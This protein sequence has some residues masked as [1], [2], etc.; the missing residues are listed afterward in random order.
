MV[1]EAE[2]SEGHTGSGIQAAQS[3]RLTAT[4]KTDSQRIRP[5]LIVNVVF[6]VPGLSGAE[7]AA[8]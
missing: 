8:G 3:Q 4:E 5:H 1:R 2:D 6:S 7:R